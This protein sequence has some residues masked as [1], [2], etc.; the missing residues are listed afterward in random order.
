MNPP[1]PSPASATG[2][3]AT[4][5]QA[6][7]SAA[8]RLASLADTPRL[9]AE[10]LLAHVLGRDRATLRAWPERPLAPEQERR[11]QALIGQRAEG[12]PVAY[13][14][15]EREFWSRRFAVGPS[16]LIPR[17]ETELL[18][19]LA[20]SFMPGGRPAEILDLGTGSGVIAVTLAAERPLARTT[21]V[22][23]SPDALATARDN[24]ARHGAASIRFLQGSWFEPL[25]P[26]LRFDLVVSNP[27]YVADEDPHLRLGDL[28][29]EPELALRAGSE[30]LDALAAIARSARA[31]LKPDGRLLLEHGYDQAPALAALLAGLDYAE[32]AHHRDLQ[33]HPR[34]TTARWPRPAHTA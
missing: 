22:D 33:G 13:L 28:R 30:G 18:I 3:T 4:L 24:A 6:L 34:A 7:K 23:I 10:V 32:I 16:V 8:E 21:A 25:A 12:V 1:A 26:D 20:L 2:A 27:P 9:D 5:G 17:P 15:G 14:V 31:W 19:E 11:F 29:F